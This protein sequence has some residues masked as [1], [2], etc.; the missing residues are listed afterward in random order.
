ME[1]IFHGRVILMKRLF[2]GSFGDNSAS[3][4]NFG[5]VFTYKI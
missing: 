5:G 4:A 2:E 1:Y 3:L